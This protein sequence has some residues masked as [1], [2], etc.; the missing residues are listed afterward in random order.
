MRIYRT[1]LVQSYCFTLDKDMC[2]SSN[3]LFCQGSKKVE[4]LIFTLAA[5]ENLHLNTEGF[6]NMNNL[7]LLQI[8]D[9]HLIGSYEYLP[10]KLKWLCWHKCPLE[11]LPQNF[12]LENLV[13]LD[14]QHSYVEQVWKEKKV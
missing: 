12:H 11:S 6:A 10:K 3:L 13:I 5:P 2:Y 7:R 4:G 14:M 1:T 9:V 8:N